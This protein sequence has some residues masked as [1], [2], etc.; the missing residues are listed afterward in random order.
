MVGNYDPVALLW[1]HK[2]SCAKRQCHSIAVLIP[3]DLHLDVPRTLAQLHHEDRRAGHFILH[4]DEASGQPLTAP[5]PPETE[6]FARRHRFGSGNRPSSGSMRVFRLQSPRSPSKPNKMLRFWTPKGCSPSPS[7]LAP[8]ES[9]CHLHLKGARKIPRHGQTGMSFRHSAPPSEALII[10]GKPMDSLFS[11]ACSTVLTVPSRKMS[12]NAS[13]GRSGLEISDFH[14]RSSGMVP[15]G[16]K[17]ACRPS[18][19]HGM[20]GTPAVWAKMLALV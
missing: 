16:P 12:C 15:S 8:S 20:D 18:P 11:F 3:D 5:N 19:L 7:P 14:R 4:L 1:C 6:V 2:A 10:T 9:P 17:F 13:W